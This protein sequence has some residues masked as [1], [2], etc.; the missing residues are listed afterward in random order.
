MDPNIHIWYVWQHS[1]ACMLESCSNTLTH[2]RDFDTPYIPIY[3]LAKH[4][5]VATGLIWHQASANH[6]VSCSKDGFLRFYHVP[7]EVYHPYHHIRTT[8]VAWDGFG[9]MAVVNDII[10]RHKYDK[11]IFGSL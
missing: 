8:A 11:Y 4:N 7:L 2:C 5:D 10:D 1:E 6:L 3:S 9:N